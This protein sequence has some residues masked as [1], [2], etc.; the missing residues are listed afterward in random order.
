MKER[1]TWK[2]GAQFCSPDSSGSPKLSYIWYSWCSAVINFIHGEGWWAKMKISGEQGRLSVPLFPSPLL[3]PACLLLF[4]VCL[5]VAI[6]L[7]QPWCTHSL[8]K[9]L[10]Q[11]HRSSLPNTAGLYDLG[12]Y[13]W[14]QQSPES[15]ERW[16]GFPA[17]SQLGQ[18]H[19]RVNTESCSHF[20]SLFRS[21]TV[22]KPGIIWKALQF[23]VEGWLMRGMIPQSFNFS[24]QTS[25]SRRDGIFPCICFP[26]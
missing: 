21:G 26:H 22:L 24:F 10:Y 8:G 16:L 25:R 1:L 14:V 6:R 13:K 7:N 18:T 11:Y 12:L 23:W 20:I 3:Q 9:A 15:V 2:T 19:W 5:V 4:A 17:N